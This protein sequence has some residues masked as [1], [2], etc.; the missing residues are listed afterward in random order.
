[1]AL[2]LSV[3]LFDINPV[4]FTKGIEELGVVAFVTY[5]IIGY[6]ESYEAK[7]ILSVADLAR[8]CHEVGLPFGVEPIAVGGKVTGANMS[9]ILE[10][11]ARLSIELGADFLKIPYS[12]DIDSF[13][14][15]VK[16][17][18]DVPVL[19][20]GGS[21][22]NRP[23]DAID[24]AADAK[25]AGARGVVFGR[26]VTQA[27]DPKLVVSKLYELFHETSVKEVKSV[28][29]KIVANSKLCTNCNLCIIACNFRK[30]G[31]QGLKD[32]V[33]WIDDSKPAFPKIHICNQCGLCIKACEQKALYFTAEGGIGLDE[34][35]CNGC[36]KCAEACPQGVIKMS[37]KNI[38]Y[39]C[40]LCQG[41][42]E[43]V[44]A[45]PTGAL[46]I[47]EYSKEDKI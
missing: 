42:P 19:V 13:R 41:E 20:L 18:G 38:P 12:G 35:K 16:A 1:M 40:D 24:I 10:Y 30:T 33:I 29:R 45:C 47:K 26:N 14:C 9:K 15:I 17:S 23:Q 31:K 32:A 34:D 44:N 11:G 7:N 37:D 43:C 21:R 6:E 25:T 3:G 8:E 2:Q 5:L 4:L 22:S 46:T 28:K 27:D 36:S 39:V